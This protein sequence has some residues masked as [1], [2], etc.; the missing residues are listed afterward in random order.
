MRVSDLGHVSHTGQCSKPPV[1]FFVDLCYLKDFCSALLIVNFWMKNCSEDS[2]PPKVCAT[3]A[4]TGGTTC[5][6]ALFAH[7][8]S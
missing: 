1:D 6:M 2:F 7:F 8:D 5:T 3:S 4:D